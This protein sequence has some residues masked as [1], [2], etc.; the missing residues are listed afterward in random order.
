MSFKG[1]IRD[2]HVITNEN[3]NI[4]HIPNVGFEK[5]FEWRLLK[6]IVILSPQRPSLSPYEQIQN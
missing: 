3:S 2:V 6:K 4:H 1:E 5:M